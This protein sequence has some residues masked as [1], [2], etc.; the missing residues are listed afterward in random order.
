VSA[1]PVDTALLDAHL[2]DWDYADAY[3]VTL[4]GPGPDR[5]LTAVRCLLGPGS[6]RLVLRARD[7]VVGVVGLKPAV[8]GDDDLFPVLLDTPHL[9]VV[10]VNDS[11]L[12][13]R[14]L[15][16][17]DRRHVRCVTVVRRHNRLGQ[18]YFATVGPF[19]RRLVPYLLARAERRKWKAT[20]SSDQRGAAR[21]PAQAP[22]TS[23]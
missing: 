9:A 5:A 10:G 2:S 1:V 11:H 4:S 14:I 6:G 12:D 13:F 15:V 22:R 16:S 23:P 20:A 8:T 3:D 19:H 18:A 7:L 21:V 17:L